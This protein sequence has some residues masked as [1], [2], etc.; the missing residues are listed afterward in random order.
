M[1]G[2]PSQMGTPTSLSGDSI[3]S[4]PYLSGA[5]GSPWDGSVYGT[6]QLPE[7]ENFN[8]GD[9]TSAAIDSD[10]SADPPATKRK[11]RDHPECPVR[12]EEVLRKKPKKRRMTQPQQKILVSDP[13]DQKLMDRKR[14]TMHARNSRLNRTTYIEGLE[15]YQEWATPKIARL[16]QQL[17]AQKDIVARL[18]RENA[19]LKPITVSP[20]VSTNIASRF[21]AP[22]PSFEGDWP[23]MGKSAILIPPLAGQPDQMSFFPSL[24]DGGVS[25][26]RNAQSLVSHHPPLATISGTPMPDPDA[27]AQHEQDLLD[28]LAEGGVL[29]SPPNAESTIPNEPPNNIQRS[30]GRQPTP[31][32]GSART[33]LHDQDVFFTDPNLDP[34]L[35]HDFDWSTVGLDID[36]EERPGGDAQ[37]STW[38][39]R[40]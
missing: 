20:P 15:T 29:V 3:S 25:I 39:A 34:A 1:Y 12:L 33:L 11:L 35:G 14:N 7:L 13:D 38:E 30:L 40:L 23:I 36:N 5:S 24:E 8:L 17:E 37:H 31:D 6:P 32:L 21:G 16:E 28:A 27:A 2:S 10:P 4:T 26:Q 19:A 9:S 22:E 18:Q